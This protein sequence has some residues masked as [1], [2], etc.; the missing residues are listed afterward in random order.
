[1]EDWKS[2]SALPTALPLGNQA[3]S[4][5]KPVSDVERLLAQGYWAPGVGEGGQPELVFVLPA[6]R[7]ERGLQKVV[8]AILRYVEEIEEIDE[9][10]STRTRQ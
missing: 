6:A 3:P 2:I 10:F 1:M 8:D 5:R 9:S 7:L 4:T